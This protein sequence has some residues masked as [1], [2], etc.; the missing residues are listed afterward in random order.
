MQS[1]MLPADEWEFKETQALSLIHPEL[2]PPKGV[3][4]LLLQWRPVPDHATYCLWARR[5]E[6]QKAIELTE[7]QEAAL[8]IG[9]TKL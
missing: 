5:K 4:W 1:L 9:R 6:P 8:N 3:G 7:S 2:N